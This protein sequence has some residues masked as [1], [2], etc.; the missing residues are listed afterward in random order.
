MYT[1]ISYASH[2]IGVRGPWYTLSVVTE[3]GGRTGLPSDPSPRM[4]AFRVD[5]AEDPGCWSPDH[6]QPM[7][8]SRLT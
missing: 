4:H 7:F 5:M 2:G 3:P 1:R 6:L 8:A